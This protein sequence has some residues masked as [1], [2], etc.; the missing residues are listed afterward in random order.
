MSG[1][2]QVAPVY[3]SYKSFNTFFNARRED[4]HVTTAVDRSLMSNFSGSTANE[5][6]AALKFLKMID[7]EGTPQ[8]LYEQYVVADD[9]ARKS[10]LAEAMKVSYPFV[11]TPPFN[12]ERGTSA[13][14]A[15]VFRSQG[16]SGSTLARAISF[17]LSA[18]KDV[19]IKVSPNIKVPT[20]AKNGTSKSKK[21]APPPAPPP[22]SVVTPDRHDEPS[23]SPAGA[24]HFEIPIPINRKVRITI[25]ADWSASDWDLFQTML[26]AYITGWKQL[27]VK[28]KIEA[29]DQTDEESST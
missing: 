4:G 22:A 24:Q 27:T 11:F 21:E 23:P 20:V 10:L 16:I 29:A 14:M 18:A 19:G 28:A 17:F 8:P 9:E 25:P 15:E 2:R 3:A 5:L 7:D 12:L 13:Q 1:E 6:L 26:S